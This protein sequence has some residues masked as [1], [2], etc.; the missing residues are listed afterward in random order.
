M[1]RIKKVEARRKFNKVKS[2][3]WA[4]KLG[5]IILG[6]ITIWKILADLPIIHWPIQKQIYSWLK[7]V[8]SSVQIWING[9][10][11]EFWITVGRIYQK[12]M[13]NAIFALGV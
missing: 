6:L 10:I 4:S 11:G 5:R 9:Q 8:L 12:K 1:D 7:C 3:T 2:T 13:K